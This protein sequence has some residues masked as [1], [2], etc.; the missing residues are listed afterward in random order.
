[1]LFTALVV[2]LCVTSAGSAGHF[3]DEHSVLINSAV[4]LTLGLV[5]QALKELSGDHMQLIE[6]AGSP[7]SISMYD[8]HGLMPV[9]MFT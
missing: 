9:C 7:K 3:E 5:R 6:V 4:S 8:L 2:A 1:M